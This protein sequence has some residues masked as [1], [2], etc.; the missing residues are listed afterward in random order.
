MTPK[1]KRII[2]EKAKVYRHYVK[3]GCSIA[4]YQSLCDI[5]SR[6]KNAIKEAKS[7]YFSHLGESFNDQQLLP[8]NTD[9][10]YLDFCINTKYP[11]FLPYVTITL[12]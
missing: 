2:L 6:C 7:N 1:I 5:I 10:S 11:K 8:K 3:H 9:Q 4:D 12:F